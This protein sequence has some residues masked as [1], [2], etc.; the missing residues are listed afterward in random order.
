MLK[1]LCKK[2]GKGMQP[3][4]FQYSNCLRSEPKLQFLPKFRMKFWCEL[5][6]ILRSCGTF[7]GVSYSGWKRW[8]S[9]PDLTLRWMKC[10]VNGLLWGISHS[11]ARSK[12]RGPQDSNSAMLNVGRHLLNI[13]TNPYTA[14]NGKN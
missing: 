9:D 7:G 13:V 11:G 10:S 2:H 14:E 4:V 12:V 8:I 6:H 1:Q 5:R 3:L